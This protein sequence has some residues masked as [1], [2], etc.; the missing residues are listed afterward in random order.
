[1]KKIIYL[2]FITAAVWSAGAS[3]TQE[4]PSGMELRAGESAESGHGGSVI[5]PF[6]EEQ[7]NKLEAYDTA[8]F[9]G[10]CFWCLEKP[11]EQLVGVAEVISGYSGGTRANPTYEQVA[12]GRTDHRESVTV[13]YNADVI[14]YRQLLDVFWRSIDP[15]DDGGQFAD[16]GAHYV[17]AIFVRNNEERQAAEESRQALEASGKFNKP[18]S[19]EILDRSV[20][21]PA[22]EYHQDYYKKSECAYNRYFVGSGRGPFIDN[23]WSSRKTPEGLDTKDGRWAN[24]D[25]A[26]QVAALTDLQR[27]VTQDDGTERAFDNEYDSNKAEGIYV[28]IVSG[29][30]LFSST[31]KYDSGSGWPSFTR[32]IDP[33]Y[34][35]YRE[36][37]SLF[38]TRIEVR[39]RFADSHL[40]HVFPDGPEPTGQRFCM[41]SASMRFVPLEEMKEEGYGQYLVFF[42]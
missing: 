26:E 32:P 38:S 40:G 39:S 33:D 12:G 35:Y 37:N 1:M 13:Y 28:D 14:S 42:E 4:T 41:N 3:G 18:I 11:Y 2:I 9:A 22:E 20:F 25:K 27:K 29:E 21:Y 17:P 5:S 30:P 6:P 36:D 10:G 8:V 34:V 15:T 24:F 23:M 19:T 16:R 7:L 31:D